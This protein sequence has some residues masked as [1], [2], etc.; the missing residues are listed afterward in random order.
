MEDAAAQNISD[1][2]G[3]IFA[4]AGLRQPVLEIV[5]AMKP[6]HS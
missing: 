6:D 5:G 2:I 1:S 3:D 4:N